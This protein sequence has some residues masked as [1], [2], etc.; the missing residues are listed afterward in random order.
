MGKDLAPA[1]DVLIGGTRLGP[2]ITRYITSVEYESA[3]GIA[4]MA[5]ITISNPNLI[6]ANSK[7]WQPGNELLIF[8][9]YETTTYI[10][11]VRIRAPEPD[12]PEGG[13]PSIKVKGYSRD[14]EM[15][16]AAP[17]KSPSRNRKKKNTNKR[18]WKDASAKEI[19]EEK[20]GDYGFEVDADDFVFGRSITQKA[21]ISDYD[22]VKGLSNIAGFLF[23]V[24]RD[25]DGRWTMHF[26]NP[27]KSLTQAKKYTFF[28]NA[29]SRS[30]LLSFQPRFAVR[31]ART[32][33]KVLVR[34]PLTGRKFEEEI[35]DDGAESVDL[36]FTGDPS[37]EIEGPI[38]PPAAVKIL[39]G[40]YSIETLSNK[41]FRT[42][43]EVRQWALQWFRRQRAHFISG[44]GS[45]VG[46]EDVF[47]R[48]NHRLEGLG[49]A[50]DGDYYFARVRHQ[51]DS[52]G[53]YKLDFT[54]RKVL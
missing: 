42:G 50:L 19:L 32:M 6:F 3:D 27:Q 2:E 43:A 7:I 51:L 49:R 30:S 22:L 9:G 24:D 45:I 34:D 38:P 21:G 14:T 33:L 15:M 44:R 16:D 28:Y 41:H 25:E 1:Y 39:F 17:V 20:A 53:G 37:S 4:D 18:T 46:T 48:Q 13:M 35:E 36:K 29:G 11:G 31:D 23:W 54:A 12:Y 5:S 26:R 40:E 10:G 52:D 47:A 8:A